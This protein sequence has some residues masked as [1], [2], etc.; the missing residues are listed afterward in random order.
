MNR[1]LTTI[2][3]FMLLAASCEDSGG[4]ITTPTDAP[5]QST[6]GS[7]GGGTSGTGQG[8]V[9]PG[10]DVGTV[11]RIK[12][13]TWTNLG[14]GD[15][16]VQQNPR[17]LHSQEVVATGSGAS[18]AF[19]LD[20]VKDDNNDDIECRVRS[21]T[22][23]TILT[24][25]PDDPMSDAFRV[26]SMT[27]GSVKCGSM[28][29]FTFSVGNVKVEALGDPLVTADVGDGLVEVATLAGAAA[30][31][32]D[33]EREM[34]PAGEKRVVPFDGVPGP[35]VL[36][37]AEDFTLI[38]LGD[39]SVLQDFIAEELVVPDDVFV[40][41]PPRDLGLGAVII[42][43]GE[44]IQIRALQSISGPIEFLGTDQVRGIEL[45]LEDFGPVLGRSV[46]LGTIE[47]DLCSAE[48]GTSGAEAIVAQPDVIG[49]IGTSCSGAATTASQI[50]SK[51]GLVMISGSNTSPALTSDTR[52]T[53]G[54]AWQPGYYRTAHN[55]TFQGETAAQFALEILGLTKVAVIHDGDPYTEGLA[56]AFAANFEELGGEI[57]LFTAVNK[58]D[59]DMVPV[60]TAAA[61][62]GPEVI[63]LPIFR[64]AGDFII[65]QRG[66]VAG[67]ED[68]VMFGADGLSVDE[69]LRLPESEGMYFS[70][71]DLDF[72]GT[73]F[74]G[75]AYGDLRARYEETYGEA[76]TT[77]FYAH[78]YDATMMVLNVISQVA[79]DGPEGEL[80]LDRQALRDALTATTNFPGVTG[81][82]SC[83]AFGDCGSQSIGIFFHRDSTLEDPIDIRARWSLQDGLED[84]SVPVG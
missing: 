37:T 54:S 41:W 42:D 43:Q 25:D 46:D 62:T 21:S 79:V 10:D 36:L 27:G 70:G 81:D 53:A 4:D 56:S 55:D 22:T 38:D 30:V 57:T 19:T 2:V 35:A 64:P 20:R 48:G 58:G 68:V 23:L 84:L 59:S 13:E 14:G 24:P 61:A 66:G 28:E 51:A 8:T 26:T 60:L 83:D 16:L 73:G 40:Q 65:Q 17:T 39:L 69:F 12:P 63:Y 33:G 29:E 47:D 18:A 71:P 49:V 5:A 15:L 9:E 82:L 32:S 67:L 76:P 11:R 44:P 52:R 31:T 74:T 1:A 6:T 77:A 7:T 3:V 78:S 45:A 72:G 80:W 75:V 50:L 34:I